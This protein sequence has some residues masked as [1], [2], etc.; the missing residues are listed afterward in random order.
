MVTHD[1]HYPLPYYPARWR[2]ECP[3]FPPD[4]KIMRAIVRHPAIPS[5]FNFNELFPFYYSKPNRAI[6]AFFGFVVNKK[7]TACGD[8][9]HRPF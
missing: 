6:I 2:G 1:G 7:V 4:I 8:F 5:V 3:D 9:S